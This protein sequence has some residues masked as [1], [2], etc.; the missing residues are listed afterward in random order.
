MFTRLAWLFGVCGAIVTGALDDDAA[1]QSAGTP[2]SSLKKKH[3]F[4]LKILRMSV[5]LHE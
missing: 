4:K 3:K 2:F 1:E 5:N